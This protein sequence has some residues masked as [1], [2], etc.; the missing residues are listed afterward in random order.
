MDSFWS[1]VASNVLA[2]LLFWGGGGALVWLGIL[3]GRRRK[4][5]RFFGLRNG[6]SYTVYLSG[7]LIEKYAVKDRD[8]VPRGHQGLAIPEYEFQS[9]PVLNRVL[10]VANSPIVPDLF[11]GLIDG[12]WL[13][14]LP[15]VQYVPSPQTFTDTP[16][17]SVL[18]IGGPKFN[19]VTE[20]FLRTRGALFFTQFKDPDSKRW[21]IVV[22]T[23]SRKDE[24]IGADLPKTEVDVGY[25][26]RLVDTESG[27]VVFLLAGLG[28]NGT[29]AAAHYLEANWLKLYARFGNRDFGVVFKCPDVRVDLDGYLKITEL[30]TLPPR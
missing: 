4:L 7:Y 30:L 15:T 27:A 16:I 25:V 24:V 22:N 14:S 9:I 2:N 17:S 19:A 13:L 1:G 5:A 23:G 8:G 3:V 26:Q 11:R 18:C 10:S 20:Y 21:R 28:V 6:T 29:R 12:L